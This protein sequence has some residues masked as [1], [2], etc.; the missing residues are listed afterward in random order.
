MLILNDV[1]DVTDA[2]VVRIPCIYPSSFSSFCPR[3]CSCC[4]NCYFLFWELGDIRPHSLEIFPSLCFFFLDMPS[5]QLS[6]LSSFHPPNLT[7]SMPIHSSLPNILDPRFPV[8]NSTGHSPLQAFCNPTSVLLACR[9]SPQTSLLI[10][11][12]FFCEQ[13]KCQ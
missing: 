4:R 10:L 5:K 6:L 2:D 7:N 3:S 11:F 9:S 13:G 12:L 8:P 1:T